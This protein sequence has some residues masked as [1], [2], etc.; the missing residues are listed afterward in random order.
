MRHRVI[1]ASN[2]IKSA[3]LFRFFLF[4]FYY[5]GTFFYDE[6]RL[7]YLCWPI[8]GIFHPF[9]I[10]F[11]ITFY[12]SCDAQHFEFN[13]F[14]FEGC[15]SGIFEFFNKIFSFLF[16]FMGWKRFKYREILTNERIAP[17]CFFFEKKIFDCKIWFRSIV[18]IK[19]GGKIVEL[20]FCGDP[21]VITIK[22]NILSSIG[23]DTELILPRLE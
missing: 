7:L 20:S 8:N 23:F 19:N 3:F 22:I 18:A 2:S 14:L 13:G 9:L 5:S 11:M 21:D 10:W 12:I 16:C 15:N 1:A 6:L 17:S 4:Q